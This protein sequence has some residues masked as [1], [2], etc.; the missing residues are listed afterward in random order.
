MTSDFSQWQGLARD[1][2]VGAPTRIRAKAGVIVKKSTF[3]TFRD[4]QATV[5]VDTG[6]LKGS[7][8]TSFS[9]SNAAVAQGTI[10]YTAEY[11][12]YVHDGTSRQAPQ[13]WLAE[14][15]DRNME[16]FAAAVASIGAVI[17]E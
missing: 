12:E 9:G 17:L 2:K 11:A 10:E 3:D 15:F 14:A 8:Q 6:N 5:P 13:P 4:A 16:P 7:G 1:L